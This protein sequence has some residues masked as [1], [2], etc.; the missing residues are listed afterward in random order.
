MV[1]SSPA[2]Q[3]IFSGFGDSSLDFEL[4][5][6]LK[7][8]EERVPTRHALHTEINDAFEK[9]GISIPFPQR[10]LHVITPGAPLKN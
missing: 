4:R 9:A 5:T 10:D 7:S 3:A 6:F 1:L 8:F 2:P